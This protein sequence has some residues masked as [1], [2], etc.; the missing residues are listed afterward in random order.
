MSISGTHLPENWTEQAVMAALMMA[1]SSLLSL[2]SGAENRTEDDVFSHV[3]LILVVSAL[4][5]LGAFGES[6]QQLL[7]PLAQQ[8]SNSPGEMIQQ[9][10][11]D[12]EMKNVLTV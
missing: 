1:V 4:S 2:G 10:F 6:F 9:H 12:D 7:R 3:T 8:R 11:V 5:F